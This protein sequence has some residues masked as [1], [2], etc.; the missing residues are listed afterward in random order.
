M[1]QKFIINGDATIIG[2]GDHKVGTEPMATVGLG[3][4]VAL[5]LFDRRSG[6]GAMAHV[7]LPESRGKTE[8][9]GKFADTAIEVLLDELEQ[10]GV[11]KTSLKAKLV[12]GASM[13]ST[14][15][16]NLN[17]GERNINALREL[18]E[19]ARITIEKEDVGGTS[20]RSVQFVPAENGK[21]VIKRADGIWSEM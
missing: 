16:N 11:L 13:F 19:K 20:G 3:S 9:P 5:I 12:G 21:V 17:I 18:L 10:K 7:M 4:C 1:N 2:I 8:K 6:I 14:P 15:S